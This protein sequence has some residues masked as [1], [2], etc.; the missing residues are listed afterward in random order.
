MFQTLYIKYV[1]ETHRNMN[2]TVT[3]SVILETNIQSQT[4]EDIK[5]VTEN[6]SID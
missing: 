5:P 2:V 3:F 4:D 1:T 6:K